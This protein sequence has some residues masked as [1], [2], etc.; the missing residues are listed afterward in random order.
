MVA[1]RATVGQHGHMVRS[2]PAVHRTIVVVD[3]EGFGDQRR[4][5][6]HQVAVR[7]GVYRVLR[8]ALGRAGI[9]WA[10]CDH[11]DRGDGVFV[12]APAQ[13]PKSHFVD[14]LPYELAEALRQHNYLRRAEERIRLRVAIHAGEVIYDEHGATGASINLTF[15]LLDA[16]PFKA[17]L[18]ASSGLLALIVSS[19]FFNEVVRQST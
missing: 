16:E 10:D 19:W 14:A 5:N 7:R 1:V 4:T 12:L 13:A 11:E 8:A 15:R 3:V 18:A 17:A 6:P 2:R 9:S